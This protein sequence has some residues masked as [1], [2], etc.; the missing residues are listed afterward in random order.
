[1]IHYTLD[2]RT[3]LGFFFFCF[4]RGSTKIFDRASAPFHHP[5]PM[6]PCVSCFLSLV[7][8]GKCSCK[9]TVAV[10]QRDRK[11]TE[12]NTASVEITDQRR[13]AFYLTFCGAI[14]RSKSKPLSCFQIR[15]S[16]HKWIV[17]LIRGINTKLTRLSVQLNARCF[18]VIRS[19]FRGPD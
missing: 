6:T 10:G 2:S 18:P 12:Y 15:T 19:Y 9:I 1:M 14:G 3:E 17:S 11:N 8:S 5:P 16:H 4:S 7:L 13:A